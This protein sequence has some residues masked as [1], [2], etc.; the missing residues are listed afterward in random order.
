MRR[1]GECAELDGCFCLLSQIFLSISIF[2]KQ[3]KKIVKFLLGFCITSSST[4]KSIGSESGFDFDFIETM[5]ASRIS[6]LFF[7][8]L[9]KS[10]NFFL[11]SWCKTP[12]LD[13]CHWERKDLK[14]KTEQL[15][16]FGFCAFFKDWLN[17]TWQVWSFRK[18][19]K[20]LLWNRK[21]IERSSEVTC[22]HQLQNG[23][24]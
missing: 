15:W 14:K 7:E 4:L 5:L 13:I 11:W 10:H 18:G 2:F 21:K 3:N 20:K 24:Q 8:V 22:K 1:G 12:L 16:D 23:F 19:M 17:K 9:E 6:S